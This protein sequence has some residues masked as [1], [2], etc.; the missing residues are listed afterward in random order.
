LRSLPDDPS[1]NY[2][3]YIIVSLIL[4]F[5]SI[6]APARASSL[7]AL[8]SPKDKTFVESGLINLVLK[9]EPKNAA[10]AIIAI[11]GKR[12]D[13]KGIFQGDFHL[14]L[15][16]VHLSTGDNT[17]RVTI[18]KDGKTIEDSSFNIFLRSDLSYSAG[19]APAGFKRYYFH[20]PENER[21]CSSCHK[22]DFSN[23][24][25]NPSA[26]E[27]SPCYLCHQSKMS[28]KRL[29]HGPAAVWACTSCHEPGN[30]KRKLAV[31]MPVEKV[32]SGCHEYNWLKMKHMHGPTAAGSCTTCHDPHGAGETY[33]LRMKTADLCVACHD[34]IIAKPHVISGFSSSAGHPVRL[35]P[36][37]LN[38]GRD[39]TCASCHN[40][41][42]TNF[43]LMLK[44]DYNSMLEF[45]QSCHKM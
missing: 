28:G 37:P 13:A 18:Q 38:P 11:N 41:H 1:M 43:P 10:D 16:G 27:Q 45:C 44:S 8:L 22:L 15:P 12:T 25:E 34:D 19:A 35:S 3:E 36:D 7:V 6:P 29:V 26:P 39:F 5:L 2:K 32:C 23:T 42:A 9:M 33:F 21:Q 30:K 40:P 17:I 14:V 4:S 20:V 31:V 24:P